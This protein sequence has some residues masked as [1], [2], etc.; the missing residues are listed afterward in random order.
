MKNMK[1]KNVL[2]QAL[3]TALLALALTPA[4]ARACACGCG[5]FDVATS[6][7]FPEGP[8]GMV[9]LDSDFQNQN[10]NWHANSEAP[11]AN[12]GDKQIRTWFFSPGV[13]YMFNR[14]WGAQ[15]EVPY[16]NRLFKTLGG[17][18]G[19]TLITEHWSQLGDIRVQ[20]IYTG[21]SPDLSTGLTFGFKLPTG[22]YTHN[23]IYGDV[24][25]DSELGTGS[26]DVLLGAFHRGN[27]TRDNRVSW[28]A[29]ALLD[30][31]A[32]TQA[33]Y[34]PGVEL[35]TAAGVYYNQLSLG[36]VRITPVAQV[37]AS[38]RTTETGQ[39]A[40]GG[41][42][43]NPAGGANSGYERILLSPGI[44]FHAHPVSVYADVELPVFADFR[45]NQLVASALF[46]VILSYH[47]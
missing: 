14:S 4:A 37:I 41:G 9:Y 26:T 29:Q 1:N 5:V 16:D 44:E 28:F 47:F 32:L 23:D 8:G 20:G 33:H 7:M 27:V 6:S 2:E 12:N 31:P 15:I 34:R 18:N 25:R 40:S 10:M 22:S 42:S 39:N 11:A 43:D 38:A 46:K 13:Q 21:F 17:A 30:V 45:G 24:D 19:N 3:S 36:R 35:D